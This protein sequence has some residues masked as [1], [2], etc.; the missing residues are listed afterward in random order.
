MDACS[1]VLAVASIAWKG[2]RMTDRNPTAMV[3][4]HGNHELFVAGLIQLY[5]PHILYLTCGSHP[6][7]DWTEP[8]ARESLQSLGFEGLVTFLPVTERE[9][10]QRMLAGDAIW[11]AEIR[12]RIGSWL[13]QV[14][15]E[16]VFAD[17]FEWYNPVHDL[18]PLLVDAAIET[19]EIVSLSNPRR[20]DLP[21]GFQTTPQQR[22]SVPDDPD[23]FTLKY[24]LS[25]QQSQRKRDVLTNLATIDASVREATSKW[26]R[27][28]LELEIYRPVPP[29]RDYRIAPPRDAWKTYDDHGLDNVR[30]GRYQQAILFHKHYAPL[31]EALFNCNGSTTSV[32][33]GD[34][35]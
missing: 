3:F 9:I 34:A 11:F 7:N 28:R 26:K 21:L 4:A 14:Q 17:A 32:Q 16:V 18:C 10:Y 25:E 6:E 8:Q 20:Y 27:E 24:L 15:P 23:F 12:D 2:I 1:L 22:T 29:E 30:H 35:A 19:G 5:Q 31:A 33:L 13:S